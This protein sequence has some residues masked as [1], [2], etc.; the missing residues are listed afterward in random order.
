M[1]ATVVAVVFLGSAATVWG[2]VGA[3]S[4]QPPV[5]PDDIS[6]ASVP[7]AASIGADVTNPGHELAIKIVA[8]GQEGLELS[9]RL[10]DDGGIIERNISWT[11]RNADGDTVFSGDTAVADV[12]VP[13]GDYA[14]DVRYGAARL[15]STITLLDGNRVNVSFVLN[16]GGLRVLPRVRDIGLPVAGS[17]ARIFA[18][19]GRQNGQLVA[20][21]EIPGEILRVPE[22]DYRVESRFASGN[23]RAVIDVHVK[24]GRMSAVD[25]DHK[26]G[27]ARL[28]FVGSPSADV[29]WRVADRDGQ[30]VATAKGLNADIVLVPGT[31][32]ASANVGGEVLTATFDIDT[33]QA[34]DIILGNR[35]DP[36][37]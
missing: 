17:E 35:G 10:T 25:V 22:G 27:V 36:H 3:F 30:P 16:A 6:L 5:Q 7:D 8:P 12:S 32:T 15:A 9:A 4:A 21:S 1:A 26:A 2:P 24:A 37:P 11:I 18:L 23:A 33:G 31:Y 19:G 14:V 20:V 28:A 29:N 13:P 34:R